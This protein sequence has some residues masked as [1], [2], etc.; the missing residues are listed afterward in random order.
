MEFRTVRPVPGIHEWE[1]LRTD[2][3]ITERKRIESALKESEQAFR[4][5]FEGA[6]DAIIWMDAS[7][8]Q[9][10]KCNQAAEDL[11]NRNRALILSQKLSELMDLEDHIISKLN[12]EASTGFRRF[13]NEFDQIVPSLETDKRINI[14]VSQTNVGDRTIFQLIARDITSL[15]NSEKNLS[16]A[17][18]LNEK[19]LAAS[20]A[21][22]AAYNS[23]GELVFVN[24]AMSS[25]LGVD[26]KVMGAINFWTDE[27]W[28]SAGLL[29]DADKA[30]KHGVQI[31]RE[32][33]IKSEQDQD[34][35][36]ECGISSFHME[37]DS[38]LLILANDI[39][40]RKNLDRKREILMKEMQN[41]ICIVSHD[42]KGP[43][44]NLRGFSSELKMALE[45]LTPL[46]EET[47]EGLDKHEASK[48]RASFYRDVP[49]ALCF[50]ESSI[51]RIQRMTSA[52]LRLARLGGRVLKYEK[53]NM[54]KL[55]SEIV[56]SNAHQIIEN[57]LKVSVDK[58]PEI[59][60]DRISMEQIMGNL[61][62]NA[63]KYAKPGEENTLNISGSKNQKETTFFVEDKG[64]GI[65]K[66]YTNQIF[67]IFQCV[68][69]HNVDGEGMGLAHVRT[70]V[71]RHN[72][73]IQ[74]E[75][76]LGKGS[77]FF[78]SIPNLKTSSN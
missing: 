38:H 36:L 7:S 44:V 17:L 69:N 30:L 41:F 52:I 27:P 64:V 29:E 59:V 60:A 1:N 62:V 37:S 40:D 46:M 43:L 6:K 16:Q 45:S 14:S 65:S 76:D 72:G 33:V 50:I 32:I 53:I 74:C 57:R 78:F 56:D 66:K 26:D 54:D 71:R 77:V 25:T 31:Q 21:G 34:V 70:L 49:E 55:V 9:V 73:E 75:S 3:D 39:S 15:K 35:W 11:F 58:L 68:G 19:I 61:I 47:L 23:K 48:F 20:S 42:L 67:E 5:T 51:K 10:I 13:D 18:E 28:K 12:P 63:I 24:K 4:L 8:G 22:I 2:Q